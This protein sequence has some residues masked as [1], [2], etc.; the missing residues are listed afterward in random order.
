MVSEYRKSERLDLTVLNPR[1]LEAVMHDE[2]PLLVLAGAGSGKTR[3]I[4]YRIARLMEEGIAPDR[5]LGV[6]FTNKSAKEM[7]E[8]LSRLAGR[9]GKKVVLSTFHALGLS[10]LKEEAV[11]VGLR[12]G[13]CIY[14]TADQLSLVRELMR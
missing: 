9:A 2:G 7:R 6:T 3:V 8:R 14:D 11:S 1:Q 12:P 13:F 10:I 5:I 4:M